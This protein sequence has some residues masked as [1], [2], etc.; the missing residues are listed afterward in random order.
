LFTFLY[1]PFNK[2]ETRVLIPD[3]AGHSSS[4][5]VKMNDRPKLM[6]CAAGIFVCYFY[7]G[8]IQERI[9][10]GNYG[11]SVNPDGSIGEKFTCTLALVGVQCLCNWL[12]AKGMLS[13][14]HASTFH[15]FW[16]KF[17]FSNVDS[18]TSKSRSNTLWILCLF[19]AYLFIGN[20]QL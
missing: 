20:G 3:S 13:N 16:T 4:I 19:C 18:Q 17:H 12:F 14:F 2:I 9:T 10:R 5:S 1:L 7:F 11:D 8:I 6:L 15:F